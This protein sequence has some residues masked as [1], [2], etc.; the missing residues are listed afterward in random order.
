MT[1][2]ENL[3]TFNPQ[4]VMAWLFGIGIFIILVEGAL[5]QVFHTKLWRHAEKKWDEFTGTDIL[6]LKPWI[7]IMLCVALTVN[8]DLDLF[9]FLFQKQFHWYSKIFTGLFVA[10]GSTGMHNTLKRIGRLK[11]ATLNSKIV[12]LNNKPGGLP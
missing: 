7:S 5:R 6:D 10:G 12:G 4:T 8:M 3:S 11:E 1:M 9:A 2:G